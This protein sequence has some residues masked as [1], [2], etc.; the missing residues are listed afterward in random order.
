MFLA[1]ANPVAGAADAGTEL[2]T[3]PSSIPDA[4]QE[5]RNA[6]E[7]LGGRHDLYLGRDARKSFLSNRPSGTP[8]LHFATHAF[9]DLENPDRSYV[10]FAGAKQGFDYLFLR[11]AATLRAAEGSLVTV[12]ACDSGNGRFERGEGI[13]SFGSAF[14]AAG[15]RA[16]ITSLWRAGDKPSAELMTRFYTFLA[17]G[18]SAA[19]A[20]R[21]AKLTFRNSAGSAAHP[22]YWATF[23]LTGDGEMRTPRVISWVVISLCVFGT[24]GLL[25]V[26]VALSVTRI[27]KKAGRG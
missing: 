12:S 18:E 6:A 16:V 15:A 8:V 25:C 9:A 21:E 27:R 23:V 10:L 20:L 3:E 24:V 19:E 5:I 7:A 17:S 4:A 1:F 2:T 26:P 14:L 11:E 13:Q 22:A